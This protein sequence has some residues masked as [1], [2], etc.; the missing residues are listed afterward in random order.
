MSE[1][2]SIHLPGL[3]GLRAIVAIWIFFYNKNLKIILYDS[4]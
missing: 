2:K 1:Q 4:K 3:N